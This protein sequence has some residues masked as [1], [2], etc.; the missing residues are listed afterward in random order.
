MAM[1]A[2]GWWLDRIIFEVFS[3]LNDSDKGSF[4]FCNLAT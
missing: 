2:R 4:R 3:H 1:A